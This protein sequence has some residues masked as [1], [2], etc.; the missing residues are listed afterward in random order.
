MPRAR[1]LRW[2]GWLQC[3]PLAPAP[4]EETLLAD[5]GHSQVGSGGTRSGG[6]RS[7]SLGSSLGSLSAGDSEAP[8]GPSSIEA[9]HREEIER[10]RFF[11]RVAIG[12]ALAVLVAVQFAAGDPVAEW[13]VYSGMAAILAGCGWL[14][15]AVGRDEAAYTPGRALAVGYCTVYGAFTGI[16]FFGPFSPG[17]VV[18][19]FGL[20]FFSLSQSFRGTLS[21]YLTCAVAMLALFVGDMTGTFATRGLVRAD[22]L[23]PFDQLAMMGLV[24]GIFLATFLI[25]RASREAQLRALEQH[26]RVV[27]DL[28]QREALLHEARQQLERALRAGG[29]GRYTDQVVGSFRLGKV[30]GRG[31]MG[32]VYEAVHAQTDAPAAVKLLQMDALGSAGA[33]RRFM[34]EA[35]IAASLEVRHVARVLEVGGLD[36]PVPY[37]AMERL[38]GTDLSEHLREHGRLSIRDTVRMARHVA[39]GL[40]AAHDAGIVHRDLKPANLFYDRTPDGGGVWKILDFGVSKLTGSTQG[41]VTRADAIIGTPEYMAPEQPQGREV[42][43]LA[44]VYALGVICY[45]ALTGTPPFSAEGVVEILF[46]VVHDM[47]PRPSALMPPLPPEVDDVL[48]IAMA[49]DPADRFAK[50][51]D[52]AKALAAAAEGAI[53]PALRERARRLEEK[54]PWAVPSDGPDV[55]PA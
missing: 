37:I 50:A 39:R 54:N 20:F 22:H 42:T 17:P 24:E 31:A 3:A 1:M 29:M 44:D 25:G 53:D 28:V 16:Y 13:V 18:I 2:G 6:T 51:A 11:L 23:P 32:E 36:A 8:A 47:P 19:P 33:V 45:R 40:E 30:L 9:V 5:D 27:R 43:A 21:V 46:Q 55:G 7:T 35:R 38:E 4:N 10:T 26:G 12:M 52:L 15:W 34:R 49:K 48:A 14:L 41:T